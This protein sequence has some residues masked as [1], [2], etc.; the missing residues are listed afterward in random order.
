MEQKLDMILQRLEKIEENQ[1]KLIERLESIE[2]WQDTNAQME[3]E[4][5]QSIDTDFA[6]ISAEHDLLMQGL[7]DI[8]P[9]I[10]N[11]LDTTPQP[12]KKIIGRVVKRS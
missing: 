8:S 2:D 6:M 3:D 4:W 12:T 7:A 11:M 10:K 9:T 5:R 1:T